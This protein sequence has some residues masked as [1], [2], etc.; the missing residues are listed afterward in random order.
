MAETLGIQTGVLSPFLLLGW[1]ITCILSGLGLRNGRLITLS[2]LGLWSVLL[3][4]LDS[5]PLHAYIRGGTGDLSVTSLLLLSCSFYWRAG[6][7]RL[8]SESS[9][10]KV[11]SLALCTGLLMYPFALGLGPVDPYRW[12]WGSELFVV[13]V[14]LVGAAF[15]L[16]E[17][18]AVAVLAPGGV[19]A[20][21]FGFLESS[22]LWDY[23]IDPWLF[24]A[25][26]VFM[27]RRWVMSGSAP[28]KAPS[29]LNGA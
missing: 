7:R 10:V 11:M 26:M 28:G 18:E 22:N 17:W 6:G 12:G 9:V 21:Q 29:G 23:L 16:L 8:L 25:S 24:I 15:W 5:V 19:L 27:G 4:R 1:A 14:C 3:V 20:W 2:V 13:S